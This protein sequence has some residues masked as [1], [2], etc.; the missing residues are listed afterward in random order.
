MIKRLLI[1]NRG[2]I[3]CRIIRSAKK[4]DIQTIAIYSDPDIKAQHVL[5]AN[6]SY[7]LGADKATESY[8]NSD[9]ILAIA[10]E[11]RADAIHP[12]YGFLAE[13]GDFSRAVSEAGFIF[14][15][16]SGHCIDLMGNKE[17]AKACAS[18]AGLPIAKD[19]RG[20]MQDK[21]KVAEAA[22][23]I[24]FP[25][26]VKASA[27]GGG[28][29]M[30]LVYQLEELHNSID[31]AAREAQASFGNSAVFLE[32]YICPARH[33]EVQIARD[34][35][36]NAIHLY[37][38]D[39]SIQRR[40]QKVV[41]EAPANITQTL[42][43]AMCSESIKL[44]NH[45][46]Y[47]GLGT[48]EFLLDNH[49]Q[50]YF[51]EM[52]TRLQVEHP[53][54][55]MITR[56]DCVAM[57]L[58]IAAGK[59]LALT[60]AD[61][62]CTGHAIE[63]RICAENPLQNFMPST[64]TLRI[65]KPPINTRFDTGFI[66]G[67][68]ISSFYDSM[69][70]KVIS[71]G[72]NRTEAIQ[73]LKKALCT[74]HLVG[75][76]TNL[77]F[78]HAILQ[79]APFKQDVISTEFIDQNFELLEK[80]IT[81]LSTDDLQACAAAYLTFKTQQSKPPCSNDYFSPWLVQKNWRQAGS[82]VE[83]LN[84]EVNG[85]Y[86]EITLPTIISQQEHGASNPIQHNLEANEWTSY[87]SDHLLHVFFRG[88]QLRISTGINPGKISELVNNHSTLS[89]P[90]PGTITHVFVKIGDFIEAGQLLVCIE[91][92]KMEYAIKAPK[93]ATIKQVYVKSGDT[94]R[95]NNPLIE[96]DFSTRPS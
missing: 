54:T 18:E 88:K 5:Q 12:G 6:E 85:E 29:G 36:G 46:N 20:E 77:E 15:G 49:N 59:E 96:L 21:M 43:T 89:S 95:E 76:H 35:H 45:I 42:E 80:N 28:K 48:L 82:Q 91:A 25:L 47:V 73:C 90:M 93:S 60:Q 79:S 16:P 74:T 70:A 24:G 31:S 55:E 13:D 9:K 66:Q 11:A 83:A 7:A 86:F 37:T 14:V 19:Y 75:L 53:I 41:E 27:G 26:L 1:A 33:I 68:E 63:A 64:G 30:R 44:A 94:T 62:T 51:M 61:I 87:E 72:K 57:Q 8:L 67:D 50:F 81:E 17:S 40:H 52:N 56:Q 65:F 34:M 2:E 78:L 39:C 71:Y 58:N 32:Q 84:L 4:L 23:A 69:I 38:R 92:M 22:Q 10:K 3:A